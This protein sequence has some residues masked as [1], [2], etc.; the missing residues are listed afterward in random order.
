MGKIK[1]LN[2]ILDINDRKT[3]EY[4]QQA[5]QYCDCLYCENFS[6]ASKQL[7]KQIHELFHH[8]GIDPAKPSHLSE[9]GEVKGGARLYTGSYHLV[10]ELIEG[11]FAVDSEWNAM[12]TA[13]IENFTIAFNKELSF[14]DEEMPKP[15]LQLD[16]EASV[17]W[18]LT[19][20]PEEK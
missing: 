3:K 14:A 2:W 12:N 10:G 7:D 1:I 20:K 6:A 19:K 8:L 11:P 5:G 16:F 18:V 13:D 15:I 9:F 17:P 4:Y